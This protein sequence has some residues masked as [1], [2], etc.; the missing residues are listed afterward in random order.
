[1]SLAQACSSGTQG[2]ES[3][4]DFICSVRL[5]H[6]QGLTDPQ[7]TTLCTAAE[8]AGSHTVDMDSGEPQHTS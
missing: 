8:Q 6:T 7:H 1:M 3:G 4:Q 5:G 2:E